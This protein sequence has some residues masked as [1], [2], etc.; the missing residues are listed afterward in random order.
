MATQ[1]KGANLSTR[2][3]NRSH[4]PFAKR[5]RAEGWWRTPHP[6]NKAEG[7]SQY[8]GLAGVLGELARFLDMKAC[9][10]KCALMNDGLIGS[11]RG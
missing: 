1:S 2:N 4:V 5:S 8:G 7:R 9:R 11:A 10:K 3:S 6:A